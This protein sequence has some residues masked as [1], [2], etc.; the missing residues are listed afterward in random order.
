MKHSLSVDP[1]SK[2]E[3][4]LSLSNITTSNR[5]KR[6][7]VCCLS[8]PPPSLMLLQFLPAEDNRLTSAW[9]LD[10][11]HRLMRAAELIVKFFKL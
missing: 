4:V 11:M 1:V 7:F 9:D 10:R 5:Y 8:C 2:E 6:S 3:S